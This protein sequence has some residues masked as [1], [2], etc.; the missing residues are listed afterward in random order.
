M[1][2]FEKVRTS[3]K[4]VVESSKFVSWDL[5]KFKRLAEKLNPAEIKEF[6]KYDYYPYFIGRE[7]ELLNYIF[8][9]NAMTFD[10]G[11]SSEFKTKR[12]R[13]DSSFY[14]VAFS[15]KKF[16]QQGKSLDADFA[17]NVTKELIAQMLEVEPDFKLAEM[18]A[19]S[20]SELGK[21]IFENYGTYSKFIT[22]LNPKN[23]ANELVEVL[24]DNL[25]F[26]KDKTMYNG[27]DVYFLKRAQLLANDLYLAFKGEEYGE[28]GD[29]EK[30]T[31][32]A[33]NLVPHF[34][35]VE[36]VLEYEES[37]EN[38]IQKRIKLPFGS[39]EEV[40]I[41]SFGVQCVE[42][43]KK[44]LVRDD[45]EITSAQIDWYLWEKSQDTKYKSFPRH[46]TETVF[47]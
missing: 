1:D 27:F 5:D 9:L 36:G 24:F 6:Y 22:E 15:L 37:L 45:P 21:F 31:M 42:E 25:S 12:K 38:K 33:D 41:R 11:L 18:Y 23:R 3:T 26:Y 2:I 7:E 4:R 29:I 19:K 40:E 17:K 34:F 16:V 14:V 32:F 47:Y 30:L 20:L 46:I 44:I 10:F 43:I 8:T 28:M 13:N 35:K 39:K